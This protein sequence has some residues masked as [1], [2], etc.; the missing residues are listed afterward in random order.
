MSQTADEWLLQEAT[1]HLAMDAVGVYELL[2]LVRGSN[3]DLDDDLAKAL[4]R[5]TVRRLLSQGNAKLLYLRWPTNE[6]VDADPEG[7]DLDSDS[8]FEPGPGGIYL[9]LVE[10]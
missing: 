7:V 9:A 8:V 3:F 6:V 5:R 4:A 10:D 1:D 2:W